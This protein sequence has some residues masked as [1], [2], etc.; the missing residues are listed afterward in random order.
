MEDNKTEI[1]TEMTD[2]E[3]YEMLLRIFGV[4]RAA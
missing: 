3:V 1:K 4:K 2:Q